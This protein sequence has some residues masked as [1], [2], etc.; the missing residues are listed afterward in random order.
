MGVYDLPNSMLLHVV[1]YLP[2]PS[3]AM[4]AA[5]LT[6]PSSS[7]CDSSLPLQQRQPSPTSNAVISSRQWDVLDLGEIERRLAAGIT[8]ENLCAILRCIEL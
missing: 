5:A 2:R 4:F 1:G 6:A 7:W 8:D 3:V